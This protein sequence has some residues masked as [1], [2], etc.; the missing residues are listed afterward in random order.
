MALIRHSAQAF[1][2]VPPPHAVEKFKCA[3]ANY[4][5][6]QLLLLGTKPLQGVGR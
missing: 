2:G 6:V 5:I 4:M 3:D 1:T